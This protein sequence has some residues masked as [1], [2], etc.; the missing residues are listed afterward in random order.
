MSYIDSLSHWHHG[1]IMVGNQKLSV[2]TV[3]DFVKHEDGNPITPKDLLIGGGSGEHPMLIVKNADLI[4]I[5]LD[6]YFNKSDDAYICYDYFKYN[7]RS[8]VTKEKTHDNLFSHDMFFDISQWPLS[9]LA[10]IENEFVKSD[11]K[12]EAN[13]ETEFLKCI[14]LFVANYL[15]KSFFDKK[16][17]DFMNKMNKDFD[18]VFEIQPLELVKNNRKKM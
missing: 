7:L 14:S 12:K 2:Y 9:I 17:Y 10:Q 3:N 15:P 1:Y 6:A 5:W 11:K 13:S 4:G 8:R 16:T 18:C